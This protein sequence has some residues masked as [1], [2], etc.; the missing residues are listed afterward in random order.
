MKKFICHIIVIATII[1][2]ISCGFVITGSAEE[3]HNLITTENYFRFVAS[4]TDAT[5]TDSLHKEDKYYYCLDCEEWFGED[6]KDEVCHHNMVSLKSYYASSTDAVKKYE[7]KIHENN[8]EYWHCEDCDTWFTSKFT[9]CEFEEN[10]ESM[11]D[12]I[13]EKSDKCFT[14]NAKRNKEYI[15]NH[16]Y[17]EQTFKINDTDEITLKVCA[18]CGEKELCDE[19]T[20]NHAFMYRERG[21]Y[22]YI[23]CAYC[24]KE[25]VIVC[26]ERAGVYGYNDSYYDW[27]IFYTEYVIGNVF[28]LLKDKD[29]N[30]YIV[31][32]ANKYDGEIHDWLGDCAVIYLEPLDNRYG[33]VDGNGKIEASDSRLVLRAA[34]GLEDY[35]SDYNKLYSCDVN[36]DTKITAE[37]ARM[38]LRFAVG[39]DTY[40][41][42]KHEH[43]D[44]NCYV[45][46]TTYTN[47]C[48]TKIETHCYICSSVEYF[49]G[50]I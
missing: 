33:D 28:A 22:K 12:C 6:M 9:N 23:T 30:K 11:S 38:I 42:Y 5:T 46:V 8:K 4:S 48:L 10:Y 31:Y 18:T 19:E 37:D 43:N 27:D 7:R 26:N 15:Y 49:S 34:V 17:E 44:E 35:N 45:K 2:T 24:G 20:C 14:C 32:S 3:K 39:L 13:I 40:D 25:I 41:M 36:Q 50:L 29:N 47:S 16:E 21:P 1:A